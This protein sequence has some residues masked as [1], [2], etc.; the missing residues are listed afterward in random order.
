MEVINRA[1]DES[2]ENPFGDDDVMYVTSTCN[3]IALELPDAFLCEAEASSPLFGLFLELCVFIF[4][5]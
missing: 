5:L 3:Q 1:H 2:L 4:I